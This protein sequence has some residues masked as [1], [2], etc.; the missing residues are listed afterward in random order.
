MRVLR[1]TFRGGAAPVTADDCQGGRPDPAADWFAE[2][3]RT[4]EVAPPG[5]SGTWH[6]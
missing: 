5:V 3:A 6:S 1:S 4:D 2:H